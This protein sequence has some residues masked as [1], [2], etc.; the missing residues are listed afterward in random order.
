METDE[1][2]RVV[3]DDFW[4]NKAESILLESRDGHKSVK[5]SRL[6]SSI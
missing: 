5:Q 4:K 6:L 3:C 2:N 1:H